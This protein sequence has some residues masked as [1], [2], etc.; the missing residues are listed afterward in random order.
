MNKVQVF[1]SKVI[2]YAGMFGA[3]LSVLAVFMNDSFRIEGLS[4]FLV[5]LTVL[6][7]Y[8][9]YNIVFN[10]NKKIKVTPTADSGG[11]LFGLVFV[12]VLGVLVRALAFMLLN[13]D[14]MGKYALI[15]YIFSIVLFMLIY[16]TGRFICN[17]KSGLIAGWTYALLPA[18]DVYM[19]ME[20][21]QSGSGRK[22]LMYSYFCI[23]LTVTSYL[24]ALIAVKSKTCIKANIMCVMSGLMVGAVLYAEKYAVA[25]AVSMIVMFLVTKTAYKYIDKQRLQSKPYKAY[26]YILFFLLGFVISAGSVIAYFIASKNMDLLPK[27]ILYLKEFEGINGIFLNIDEIAIK[28]LGGVYFGRNHF[29]TYSSILMYVFC[30]V[31][32]AVGCLAVAKNR[33]TTAIPAILFAMIVV[34][35]GIAENGNVSYICPVVPFIILV[36]GYGMSNS[37]NI[38]YVRNYEVCG[39]ELCRPDDVI[40]NE[41]AEL[42]DKY[43]LPE[44]ACETHIVSDK[45][46]DDEFDFDEEFDEDLQ[47][48]NGKSVATGNVASGENLTD[49]LD[50]LYGVK[51]DDSAEVSAEA[52]VVT[53]YFE[54]EPADDVGENENDDADTDSENPDDS[55]IIFKNVIK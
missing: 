49:M 39:N 23:A 26:K 44:G 45:D 8:A 14:I 37:V 20:S 29:I 10:K 27:W 4:V 33:K 18:F 34:C 12:S 30:L 32:S 25:A 28:L 54:E 46:D 9:I 41:S 19:V 16:T 38:A 7:I 42:E 47:E 50:D 11:F 13:V 52:D 40:K 24:F 36:A 35:L 31:M 21:M 15:T 2:P 55:V 1:F 22:S 51:K 5:S 53:E 6:V 43:E 48:D 3:V 17:H